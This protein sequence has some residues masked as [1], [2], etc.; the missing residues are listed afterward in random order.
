[1][2]KDVDKIKACKL[3]VVDYI[4]KPIEKDDLIAKIE[5]ILQFKK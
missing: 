5:K 1:L 3:G 2:V 4:A